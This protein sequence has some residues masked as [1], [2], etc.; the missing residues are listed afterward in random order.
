TMLASK[1][2]PKLAAVAA[3]TPAQRTDAGVANTT[4]A[5]APHVARS[6][7]PIAAGAF[8]AIACAGVAVFAFSHATTP[9][10]HA[11]T[12]SA[13]APPAASLEPLPVHER[14]APLELT[15]ASAPE[16]APPPAHS[17]SA[18][19]RVLASPPPS[20]TAKPHVS[21][22]ASAAPPGDMFHP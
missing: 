8:V 6:R 20:S 9:P 3:V 13:T 17:A 4:D 16:T 21:A 22:T 5:G 1:P 19:P 10:T 2:P 14:L 12:T 15:T 11:G 18:R 7:W